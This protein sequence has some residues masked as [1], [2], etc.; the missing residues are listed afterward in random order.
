[1]T[2][3]ASSSPSSE[4]QGRHVLITGAAGGI[5]QAL[6]LQL[7]QDGARVSAL[8]L[9]AQGLDHL[10]A[11]GGADAAP[12]LW[13][14]ALDVSESGAVNAA[15]EAAEQALGPIDHLAC[16]AGVL[17]MGRVTELSDEQWSRTM[18]INLGGVFNACR[19]VARGMVARQRGSIV[20]VSSNAATAPR[21]AMSAYAA[22]K[23]AVTQ[24]S[25][26]LALEL[27]EHGVRCNTVSPGSTDTEMQRAMWR[28]GSS[29][30][31]VIEGDAKAFRLGIP[32]RK[33]ATPDDVVDAILFLLS[34]RAGHITLHDMRVDGGATLDQ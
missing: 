9:D 15:I 33:I 4:F 14:R 5:G 26:C 7:L 2:R 30:E 1:M 32:L 3:N 25:R 20:N 34:D 23:A 16:V 10:R 31:T 21:A 13:T 11:S 19:A 27:A 29:R 6:A 17:Q 24:F 12:Q 22:S 28:Q 18:A 8:D